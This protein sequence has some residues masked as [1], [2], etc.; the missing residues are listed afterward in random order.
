MTPFFFLLFI[1]CLT[2]PISLQNIFSIQETL[3]I[4][5]DHFPLI[6]TINDT[7]FQCARIRIDENIP[8]AKFD[9]NRPTQMILFIIIDQS[10]SNISP[11]DI[12]INFT[13]S[14]SSPSLINE[15]RL[16]LLVTHTNFIINNQTLTEYTPHDIP[17]FLWQNST[18][19]TYDLVDVFQIE[20]HEYEI[21]T[22]LCKWNLN[23]WNHLFNRNMSINVPYVYF[24]KTTNSQLLFTLIDTSNQS[25]LSSPPLPYLNIL[26]C[27]PY[28]LEIAEMILIICFGI[29]FLIAV[30]ALSILHYLKGGENNRTRYFERYYN[31]KSQNK[32]IQNQP[33]PTRQRSDTLAS[34]TEQDD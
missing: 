14:S 5:C 11:I 2:C 8:R 32:F 6:S 23:Q 24:L 13:Q 30:I 10:S 34:S 1:L 26:Y 33:K 7:N 16:A 31:R 3:T 22:S 27:F 17:I 21:D 29:L 28:K 18:E 15:I 19:N 9:L 25:S 20:N 4:L 12:I